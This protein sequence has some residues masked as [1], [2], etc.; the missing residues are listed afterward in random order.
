GEAG[1]GSRGRRRGGHRVKPG[2]RYDDDDADYHG[3]G[4]GHRRWPVVFAALV[5]LVLLVGGAAYGFW[6]YNQKQVYVGVQN[7]YVAIFRGTNQSV[8]G[9]SLSS[10]LQRSTLPVSELRLSDQVSLT[11]TISKSNLTEAQQL[12]DGLL[13]QVTQCKTA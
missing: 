5:L 8:A 7:G 11:Q 4:R 10:L 3:G 9:I 13:G 6:Q 2:R 1:A 12:I